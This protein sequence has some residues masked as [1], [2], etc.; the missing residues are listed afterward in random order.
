MR[1]PTVLGYRDVPAAAKGSRPVISSRRATRT[2]KHS[3][4]EP[5]VEQGQLVGQR[6]QSFVCSAAIARISF[7]IVNLA[8]MIRQ[9]PQLVFGH[10]M[11]YAEFVPAPSRY[12]VNFEGDANAREAKVTPRNNCAVSIVRA[13]SCHPS[14]SGDPAAG[15][16]RSADVSPQAVE[17][18]A[19][20]QAL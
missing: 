7:S 5:R 17:S 3:E 1:S 4:F 12:T 19:K 6:R 15:T 2:A 18:I 16:R 13:N 9:T 10:H 14:Q 20:R 8:D 11:P